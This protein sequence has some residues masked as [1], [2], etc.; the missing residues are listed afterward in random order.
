MFS[1]SW[2]IHLIVSVTGCPSSTG[3]SWVSNQT[4]AVSGASAATRK[5]QWDSRLPA[6]KSS[7]PMTAWTPRTAIKA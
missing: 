2:G 7:A 1:P 6:T 5:H 4:R 3:P